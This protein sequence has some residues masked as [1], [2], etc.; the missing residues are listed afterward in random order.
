MVDE[1]STSLTLAYQ[2][3]VL[4]ELEQRFI[5]E[6]STANRQR[7]SL[8]KCENP[9]AKQET[10]LM[11]LNFPNNRLYMLITEIIFAIGIYS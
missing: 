9:K 5:Q 7:C 8:L 4:A 10:P 3:S 1:K 2:I 6:P 11:S